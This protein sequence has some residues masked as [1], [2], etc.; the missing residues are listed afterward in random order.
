[1][2]RKIV[3]ACLAVL[4]LAVASTA[5]AAEILPQFEPC[6]C[7]MG[8][9]KKAIANNLGWVYRQ[10][11]WGGGAG[12]YYSVTFYWQVYTERLGTVNYTYYPFGYQ[13]NLGKYQKTLQVVNG[14]VA[15]DYGTA[16]CW[17]VY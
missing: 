8:Y 1:M 16:V 10:S 17:F 9:P 13:Y 7:N 5:S 3:L 2:K 11:T 6:D 15:K 14:N 4:F 12:P